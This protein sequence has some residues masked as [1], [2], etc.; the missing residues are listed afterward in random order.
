[1]PRILMTLLPLLAACACL[2]G[3][4][5]DGDGD[6]GPREG[7]PAGP[8][9][10]SE[11]DVIDELAFVAPDGASFTLREV[12]ADGANELM[13]IS[14]A[15]FWCAACAEEQPDLQELHQTYGA[16]GLF[17]MVSVFEDEQTEPADA[18]DAAR[19]Q[20]LHQVDFQVVADPGFVLDAY[21]DSSLTPM[22]MLVEVETMTIFR[23][24][25][26]WDPS[27][28]RALVEAKL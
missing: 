15:A 1:M 20:S 5:G 26:G 27:A 13:L 12:Y 9:G 3:I 2:D 8:Y 10:V 11:G 22:N 21:Y 24:N 14:T 18:A 23:I 28:I 17:A 19:W 6:D 4:G 7:Y 25:T 16:D